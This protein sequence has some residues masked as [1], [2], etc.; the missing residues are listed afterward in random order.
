MSAVAH[1]PTSET[2]GRI[3]EQA[4]LRFEQLGW[5]TPRLEAWK[6]TNLAPA[7]KQQWQRAEGVQ[8]AATGMMSMAGGAVA[9]LV[10]VNG[11]YAP[12]ASTISTVEGLRVTT[13]GEADPELL[14]RHFARYA[15]YQDHALTALNT[16]SAQDGAV[17]E[18][19]GAVEGF[20]HLLF[21][22][23]D[24]FGSHPRNLIVAGRG[25]QLSVVESYGGSGR[26]FV[27]AVT[28][29]VAGGGAV[30][31]H[32]K[33]SCD[34]LEA[35]HIGTVQIHQE[36][37]SSVVSRNI[38]IG[39]AITRN[40]IN[41]VLAGEGANLV[42]DGLFVGTATQH[43]DSHTVIDHA[44]PHCESIELYKGV[45]DQQARGIFDG[46]IIVRPDARKTVSRQTNKNL[47][48]SETAIVDSKPT[49]EIFND[50]VKCNH[51]STI[52]QLDEESLFYLRS[53]GIDA[54]EARS[55][56]VYAFASEI[57]ERIL[58]EPVREQVRR[59]MFRQMPDR[60]PE[61]RAG[62]REE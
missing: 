40:D 45:L 47:L 26:Y 13:L 44:R 41:G 42:L 24:G 2:L 5:P 56:L 51:G 4:A 49:L 57:V 37:A 6:Y 25:A 23:T 46:R 38:A 11:I 29:I 35:F 55:L 15:D 60:L 12:E 20:V 58:L 43:L 31:D 22:G 59:A 7:A 32:T 50:D 34:S 1:T 3:R 21:L 16:A 62:N 54:E 48:L 30:V 17:I 39:G 8:Y 14:E 33:L 19:T 36:R 28:E 10:F 61:R 53:R 9:E 27:N 52:G 18:V